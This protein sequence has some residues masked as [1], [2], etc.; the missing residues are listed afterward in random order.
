MKKICVVIGSRANYGRLKSVMKAIDEHP[1]LQLKLITAASAYDLPIDFE[2]DAK[3]QCLMDGDDTSAMVQTTANFM[4]Q[5]DLAYRMLKPDAVF[6]HGDRFELI[7]A[8]CAARY[9]NIPIFHSEGGDQT[10]TIDN[11]VRNA[12]SMWATYHFPVTNLAKE[13]LLRMGC[14]PSKVHV[15]G[16]TA[17]DSLKGIDLSNNHTEPYVVILMHP[18]TT[19]P[20]PIEPLIEALKRIPIHQCWINPNVDSGNKAMLKLIH[21]QGDIEFIKNLPPEEYARLIFNAKCLV[22]NSSSFI[23]EASFFGIPAV[24]V[25]NR[26]QGREVGRNVV[27]AGNDAKEIFENIID[28]TDIRFDP[29]FRFGT[30][31]A[32]QK[33]VKILAEVDL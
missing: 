31:N 17:L 9:N 32:A 8:A 28:M 14:D 12:I 1:N 6:L 33:I 18:N 10:G 30:G 25:G 19:E 21:Q 26:Q 23:K 20:E 27:R 11:F 2:P 15:V 3:I 4:S 16:S 24:L 13:N 22:G 29:D 7:G 5:I